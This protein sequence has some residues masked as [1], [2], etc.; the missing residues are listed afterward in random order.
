[1]RKRTD[2]QKGFTL[3]E[4][5]V[6]VAILGMLA[7]VLS[8]SIIQVI[9]GTERNNAKIIAL[10]DIEHAASFINQDLNMAQTTDLVNGAPPIDLVDG[11]NVTLNWTDYYD[12]QAT[13][14]QSLYYVSD[15]KLKR[16]YDDGLVVTN[17]ALYIS[18]AE[19]FIDDA[20]ELVTF[21]LTSSPENVSERSET[22]TYRIYPR[23]EGG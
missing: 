23:S 4:V 21:T 10:A 5:L 8:M 18:K 22:R 3:I 15:T 2:N 13:E 19:F 17:I 20:G 16:D 1:M 9:R 12:G 6:V 7:P 14:H 11:G